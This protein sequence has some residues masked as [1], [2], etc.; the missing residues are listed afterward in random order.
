MQIPVVFDV[1]LSEG[2]GMFITVC[3]W[4]VSQFVSALPQT[5]GLLTDCLII[6]PAEMA[7]A[8]DIAIR[9]L[10]LCNYWEHI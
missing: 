2:G 8:D 7:R 5:I 6:F 1:L 9:Y 4:K 3:Q 10:V